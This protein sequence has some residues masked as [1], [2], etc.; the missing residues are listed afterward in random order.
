MKG[1]TL[2]IVVYG[3]TGRTASINKTSGAYDIAFYDPCL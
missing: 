1:R 2:L 3:R